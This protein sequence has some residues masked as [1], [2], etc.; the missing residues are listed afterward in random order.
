MRIHVD[1]VEQQFGRRAIHGSERLEEPD[2]D[3]F[4]RP[5]REVVVQLLA[6]TIAG[7]GINP[8]LTGAQHVD[9]AADHPPIIDARHGTR[10]VRQERRQALPLS[11]RQPELPAYRVL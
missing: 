10:L 1:A 9:D 8:A 11:I 7:W 4:A 3:A 2:P 6:Q 5:S